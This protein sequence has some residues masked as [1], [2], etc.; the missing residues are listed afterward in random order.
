MSKE[1]D[2]KVVRITK[3]IYK[4]AMEAKTDEYD[5]MDTQSWLSFLISKGLEK[6]KERQKMAA[7]KADPEAS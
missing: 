3:N 7:K 6:L 4:K 1:R 5:Y 2:T